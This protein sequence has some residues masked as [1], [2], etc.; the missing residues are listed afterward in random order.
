MYLKEANSGQSSHPHPCL[1]QNEGKTAVRDSALC[2]VMGLMLEEEG[3]PPPAYSTS[4]CF[5]VCKE[6]LIFKS[7]L[8]AA[9]FSEGAMHTSRVGISTFQVLLLMTG[10]LLVQDKHDL[11][12]PV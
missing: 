10:H 1:I 6:V 7:V 3:M 4:F 11:I 5:L 12:S 8:R 2:D 9:W